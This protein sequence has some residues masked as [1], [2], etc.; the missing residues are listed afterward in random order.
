MFKMD[1]LLQIL[2]EEFG[3]DSN[4]SSLNQLIKSF[5]VIYYTCAFKNFEYQYNLYF[6]I[7]HISYAN[8]QF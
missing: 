6:N 2:V 8:K 1:V 3:K 4:I 5:L 7:P